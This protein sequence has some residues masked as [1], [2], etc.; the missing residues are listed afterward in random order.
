MK[1]TR[2]QKRFRMTIWLSALLGLITVGWMATD[3]VASHLSTLNE[4]IESYKSADYDTAIRLLTAIVNDESADIEHRKEAL[5]YLG[6]CYVAKQLLDK[7]KRS[8]QDLIELE[9]PITEF[10]PDRES[11]PMMQ[12]Y[13]EAR[14]DAS[15]GSYQVESADPGLKTMAILDF[16]NSSIFDK[17]KFDPMEKG[18]ADVMINL[19]SGATELKVVE[20]ERIQ[21]ILEEMNIQN[22][23][24]TEG[25]VRAGK[26]LGAHV[27]LMGSFII[28]N[29]K[30]IWLG[31]R[32]VK[33]ESSEIILTESVEGKVDDF[34]DLANELSKK[35][36]K[37]I[38]TSPKFAM[39]AG[40]SDSNS[41][42]AMLAYS[43]GLTMLEKADYESAYQKFQEALE[44][45]PNYDRARLKAESIRYLVSY[46][47]G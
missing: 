17:E 10:D 39:E 8:I 20:R 45:D 13:Y 9:P 31:I 35:I 46:T 16:K 36:A 11:P 42:D 7:A 28:K 3:A 41:L 14:R 43:Q 40:R 32:L 22:R 5:R 29:K 24:S 27:A 1:Q 6:R 25:A 21:W 38:D 19:L 2:I 30:E 18:F 15:N 23:Y 26:L 4:G 47:E 34:F 12:V 37:A 44:L 33:V